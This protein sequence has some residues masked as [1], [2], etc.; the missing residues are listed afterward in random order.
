MCKLF[1]VYKEGCMCNILINLYCFV[2]KMGW[3]VG[4]NRHEEWCQF[5]NVHYYVS[6]YRLLEVSFT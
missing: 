4:G 5:G 3:K 2:A 6:L 1:F